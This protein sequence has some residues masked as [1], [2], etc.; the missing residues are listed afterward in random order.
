MIKRRAWPALLALALACLLAAGCG[1]SQEAKRAAKPGAAPPA[2]PAA[3]ALAL[4][5]LASRAQSLFPKQARGWY[6]QALELL[7]RPAVREA[8]PPPVWAHG[9]LARGAMALDPKLAGRALQKGLDLALAGLPEP[10]AQSALGRLLPVLAQRDP[11]RAAK[12][13]KRITRPRERVLAILELA[14]PDAGGKT[15]FAAAAK[16]ARDIPQKNQGAVYLA[17]VAQ[18]AYN[19]DRR[20]ALAVFDRAFKLAKPHPLAMARVA[21]ALAAL[22]PVAGLRLARQV[23]P[24]RG[25]AFKA[26]RISAR[27]IM[28][29]DPSAGARAMDLALAAAKDLPSSFERH[30]A[31]GLLAQDL[32]VAHPRYARSLLRSLPPG[33]DGPR[34]QARMALILAA[35]GTGWSQAEQ[36]AWAVSDPNY[37]LMTL[38]RLAAVAVRRNDARGAALYQKVLKESRR[39]AVPLDPALLTLAWRVLEGPEAVELAQGIPDA[40]LRGRA[41]FDLALTMWNYGNMSGARWCLEQSRQAI[42]SAKGKQLLDKVRVLGDMGRKCYVIEVGQALSFFKL[43]AGLTAK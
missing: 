7:D 3:R 25:A 16:A 13:L 42:K 43:A 23:D 20:W 36:A 11:A 4:C 40:F 27:G 17:L 30:Q 21:Q 24:A 19:W 10:W 29:R 33:A 28:A 34:S 38:T 18:K 1:G 5:Q 35:A 8:K 39:L 9:A 2:R 32:A 22:D 26:L 14:R 31:L 6:A 41:L 15:G 12:L 37:R